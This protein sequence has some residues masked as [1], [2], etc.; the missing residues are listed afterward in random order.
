[1]DN[2]TI[3]W[4]EV[5]TKVCSNN[6]TLLI[7]LSTFFFNYA[8]FSSDILIPLICLVTFKWDISSLTY[9]FIGY[10]ATYFLV[11]MLLSRLCKNTHAVYYC[12]LI[13]TVMQ[14]LQ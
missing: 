13:C 1:M 9:I 2:D 6:D 4:L 11:L 14:I 10:G 8:L 7:I 3:P 12:S 5:L